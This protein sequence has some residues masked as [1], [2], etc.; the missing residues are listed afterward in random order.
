MMNTEFLLQAES[1]MLQLR[2][3][4]DRARVIM[5]DIMSRYFHDITNDPNTEDGKKWIAH[6]FNANGIRAGI[7]EDAVFYIDEALK[8]L[9]TI[10]ASLEGGQ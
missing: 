3:N 5:G 8:D 2:T 10:F 7:V 1:H 9:E 6:G 4:V